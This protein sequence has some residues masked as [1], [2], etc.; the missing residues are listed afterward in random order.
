[1]KKLILPALL[2]FAAL[3]LA[4]AQAASLSPAGFNVNVTLTSACQVTTAPGNIALSYTS[5]GGATSAN[6]TFG[7]KCTDGLAYTFALD[8]NNADTLGLTIPVGLYDSTGTTVVGGG[9]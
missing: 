1:M 5:L 9:T 4:P 6:T 2:G 8:A 3:C 7:V